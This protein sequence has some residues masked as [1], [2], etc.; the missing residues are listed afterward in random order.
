LVKKHCCDAAI[1]MCMV[2]SSSS[3][4]RIRTGSVG[5]LLAELIAQTALFEGLDAAVRERIA[6]SSMLCEFRGGDIICREDERGTGLH[7]VAGG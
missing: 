1:L 2:I 4:S 7:I 6:K 3:P 5:P